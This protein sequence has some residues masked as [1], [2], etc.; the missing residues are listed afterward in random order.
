[1]AYDYTNYSFDQLQAE[2]TQKLIA[3]S[4]WVDIGDSSTTQTLIQ[5][6]A[7]TADK[8]HYMLERRTQESYLPTALLPSSV[9]ALA[10]TVGY[11]PRRK[12]SAQGT[13]GIT[14]V[15]ATGVPINPTGNIIIPINTPVLFNDSTFI[16]SAEYGIT[17]TDTFP[18]DIDIIEGSIVEL[19]FDINDNSGTLA[20]KS[21]I[22]IA[23]YEN[24]EE[25]SIEVYTNSQIFRNVL[26]SISG[27]P[28]IESL[29]FADPND[30]VYDV[31]ITH[32]GMRILVGDGS[33]GAAPDGNLLFVRYI[34][35]SGASVNVAELG[36]AFTFETDLLEDD[37]VIVPK[38]TYRY[39]MTNTTSI[40]GGIND[41]TIDEIK[42]NAPNFA[43]T[44]NR[45]VTKFDYEFWVKLSGIAGIVDAT[46]YSEQEVG[47]N[48]FNM[49]NVYVSYLKNDG[50]G[51]TAVEKQELTDYMER[52][53]SVTAYI[54]Y[55]EN[56]DIDL[57]IELTAKK[58]DDI[59]LSDSEFYEVLRTALSSFFAYQDGSL[60]KTIYLSSIIKYLTEYTILKQGVERI[61]VD[62][63]DLSI[64]ALYAFSTPLFTQSQEVI[65]TRGST[66]DLYVFEINGTD[67][68]YTQQ[69]IDTTDSILATS[70]QVYL[71]GG[72]NAGAGTLV[73]A[74]EKIDAQVASNTIALSTT[75][76]GTP[77]TISNTGST[78]TDN[79]YMTHIIQIPTSTTLNTPVDAYIQPLK[80][81]I[82]QPDGSVLFTDDGSGN[83]GNGTVD[84][85]TGVVSISV[86]PD[87]E[88]YVRY[89]F[90]S[91]NSF[92]ASKKDVFNYSLPKESFFA[93]TEL[94]ST[95]TI[96]TD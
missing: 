35:S 1:M 58:D 54:V 21:Y 32:N 19:S 24:I 55:V 89:N 92:I 81:Q 16:T 71:D 22:E 84:Y 62:F 70:I 87:G 67:Y 88:Y 11:L 60:G 39:I 37:V 23:D 75:E 4:E 94:L 26:K 74:G 56:N 40:D 17:S 30:V 8:L 31:K 34:N 10:S 28:P 49:N 93:A 33:N 96:V 18:I 90:L 57:Q 73:P 45:A 38:N 95:I 27:S 47:Y 14:I 77:F 36:K 80:V 25:D 41:E 48:V 91:D 82:I 76:A 85:T 83:I 50:T 6:L 46:C 61:V 15:D 51:L 3:Q 13:L 65:V 69:G 66:N 2:I 43:R 86:L 64:K 20:T 42:R 12:V 52:Y 79:N 63:V 5:L 59:S 44:G 72:S 68:I 78:V 29:E 53:K 7:F 9:K